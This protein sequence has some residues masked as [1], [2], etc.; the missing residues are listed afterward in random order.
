MTGHDYGYS[1]LPTLE[2]EL[3]FKPSVDALL[4]II[5][6]TILADTPLTIGIY[7]P[8][9]SGKTSMMRMIIDQIDPQSCLTVWFDAW[10]Y[11]QS[12][13]L[14]R[15]LLLS[16]VEELR[17]RTTHDDN[18]LRAYVEHRNRLDPASAQQPIDDAAL[19][20]G[21]EQLNTRFDDLI[22]SLY[23]SVDREQPGEIEFQWDQAGKLVAG[24]IIRAGFSSIPIL[25]GITKAVEKASEK[26]GE[27][28]YA[29]RILSLFQRQ[30]VKIYRDQV[31]SLE[32]F[33]RDLK[34]LVTELV[35]NLDRRLV[36]VIDDLDRCLPE[37][38]IGVLEALKVFLDVRGCIFVL[39]VDRAIIERGIRVRYKEFAISSDAGATGVFPVAGRDYLEKIVQIPFDLPPLDASVILAFLQR[40][41]PSLSVLNA[42]EAA[43]VAAL[44][45]VGL[46][47]NPRKVKRTFNV[48]RLLLALDRARGCRTPAGL[49]AKLTVIQ[50]SFADLYERIARA[51]TLLRD[52]EQIVRGTPGAGAIAQ[53]LR[54]EVGRSDARLKELL[55]MT[56][57]FD[58][59]SDNELAELVY[60]SRVT[61][62]NTGA[63]PSS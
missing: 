7:G 19:D 4:Q 51:P 16:I 38:A 39:G 34:C 44:M 48:F 17:V 57:F 33:Y 3:G 31:R 20:S 25:G 55:C 59:L 42:E 23:R 13:T 21:R 63:A 10:R 37:Q 8:W 11:A 5:Q 2:D 32:Q 53:D 41:L 12:E 50:S 27:E 36:V 61:R 49:I 52:I 58:G 45:T 28:D 14:W 54:E 26:A 22:A 62:D 47:R 18:W 46:I 24:T 30:K 43:N 6:D 35:S 15:A 60:Q 56:P 40:R 1:D 29:E 9:G